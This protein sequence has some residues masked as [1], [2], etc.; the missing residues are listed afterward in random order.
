[1]GKDEVH[2][3]GGN[4]LIGLKPQDGKDIIE[5]GDE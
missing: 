5:E 1:M 2:E 4:Y 3:E